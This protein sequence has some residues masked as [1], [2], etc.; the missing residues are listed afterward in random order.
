MLDFLAVRE[1][2]MTLNQLIAGLTTAD[3]RRYTDEM[4][5]DMLAVLQE[6]EDGDVTFQPVDPTAND[7]YATNPDELAMPWTLGHVVVH[8]TASS[9]ESAA[10]S[11]LLARGLEIKERSRYEVPWQEVTTVAQLRA[12]LQE[13]RRMRLAF[14]DSWPKDAHL[15][16][17]YQ[18]PWPG[19]E[20][21]NAIGRFAF[22]LMHDFPHLEQMREVMLQA[23]S[24]R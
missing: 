18:P 14:L 9:E 6:A 7:R 20:P 10:L 16:N 19:A 11:S 17:L 13:S 12:R 1:K 15:G 24:A 21:V 2:R 23:K 3:L 5:D 4:I 22:G 8:A